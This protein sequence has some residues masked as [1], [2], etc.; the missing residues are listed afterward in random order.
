MSGVDAGR[1]LE[2]MTESISPTKVVVIGG[3]YAGTLAA[4]HLQMR[5]DVAVTLV[6]PRPMFVERI[7]LHQHAAG[8]GSATVDYGQLLH[9]RVRLVV[10]EATA[11]DT[12]G[13]SVELSS[14]GT[15]PYDYLI[16]AVGSS[17]AAP[18]VR[19][20]EFALRIAEFEAS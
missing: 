11:I 20:A 6:N 4:N 13:R 1:C 15:L 12:A 3:G 19:G 7:R 2:G 9:E 10:D 14:G 16:Y 18:A 5:D 17:G 8:T